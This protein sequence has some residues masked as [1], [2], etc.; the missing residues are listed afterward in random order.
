MGEYQIE[1]VLSLTSLPKSPQN[2]GRPSEGKRPFVLTP[3]TNY[4]GTF[5]K[6]IVPLEEE[7]ENRVISTWIYK[8]EIPID[9]TE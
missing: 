6:S 8:E 7:S 9:L 2:Y 4:N 3:Q 5:F 1:P